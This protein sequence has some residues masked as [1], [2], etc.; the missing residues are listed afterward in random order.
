[1]PLTKLFCACP[2]NIDD[3][4]NEQL[5]VAGVSIPSSIMSEDR[6]D[7]ASPANGS[8]TTPKDTSIAGFLG[9][10]NCT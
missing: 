8:Q 2:I 9:E 6:P 3:K 5:Y 10:L 7:T 4:Q 1:M